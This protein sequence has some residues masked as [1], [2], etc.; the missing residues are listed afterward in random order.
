[1][2]WVVKRAKLNFKNVFFWDTLLS[3]PVSGE[4]VHLCQVTDNKGKV[5]RPCFWNP[6][7]DGCTLYTY[8]HH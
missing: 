8:A 5:L 2:A 6:G 4:V 7:R 3:T 1:M